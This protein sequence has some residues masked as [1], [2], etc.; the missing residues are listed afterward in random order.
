MFRDL[1]PPSELL[2]NA[3]RWISEQRQQ[4]PDARTVMLIDEASKRFDLTPVEEDFLYQAL[5]EPV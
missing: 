5:S 1:Q 3:I 2:R 4:R